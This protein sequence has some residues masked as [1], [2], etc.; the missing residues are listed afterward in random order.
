MPRY[1]VEGLIE[2][3][4]SLDTPEPDAIRT[5]L[6][7][8]VSS[9]QLESSPS[10]CRFLR[11]VVEETLAGRG[12]MIKEYSLGA[13][14][15]TRGDDFDPRIDP[16]VRVQARNLRARMAKYYEGPGAGD[17]II[18]DLPKRTYVPVF[19]TRELGVPLATAPIEIEAEA[20]PAEETAPIVNAPPV[21]GAPRQ[22]R[23]TTARVVA[24]GILVALAGAAL[25]WSVGQPHRQHDPDP[26]AQEQYIRG[27]FLM[28]RHNEKGLLDSVAA[29]ERAI[30]KD[31][32]FAAAYAGL[33][34]AYNMLAQYGF[35]A[36]P[37][38]MEKARQ[39]AQKALSLD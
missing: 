7:K 31:P 12:G 8:I 13:E 33:A 1:N 5:A 18:I 39:S 16:I 14:V 3:A 29:F 17:P 38:G 15:F 23:R 19:T 30:V 24:A 22:T 26:I 27:R 28:D 25:S 4:M 34:D 21:V 20:V 2:N 36:P 32:Q 35:V 11:Y 9:S 6:E 37:E 10:L